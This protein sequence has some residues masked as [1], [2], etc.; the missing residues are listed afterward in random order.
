MN[1][2]VEVVFGM[3]LLRSAP[4][5]ADTNIV[6]W[7]TARSA[8]KPSFHMFQSSVYTLIYCWH[9]NVLNIEGDNLFCCF[10]TTNN[11]RKAAVTRSILL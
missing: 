6:L 8:N 11:D 7:S 5:S 1:L 9:I 3:G 4:V 2:I 10:S